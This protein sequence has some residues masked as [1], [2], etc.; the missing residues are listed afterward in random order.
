MKTQLR[1]ALNNYCSVKYY[2]KEKPVAKQTLDERLFVEVIKLLQEVEDRGLFMED[3]LGV[4]MTNYDDKY[5]NI[6]E[7]LLRLHFTKPQIALIQYYLYTVPTLPD[8]DGLLDITYSS[9][10][11]KRVDFKSPA[12]VWKVIHTLA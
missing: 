8:W 6:I 12:D 1:R 7:N 11:I 5:M 2:I 10:E 9:G 4:D 3:E